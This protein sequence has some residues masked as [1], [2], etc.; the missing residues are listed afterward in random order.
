MPY[1]VNGKVVEKK[2]FNLVELFVT[3]YRLIILFFQSIFSSRTVDNH[4]DSYNSR[5]A[6]YSGRSTGSNIH[7]M[8]KPSTMGGCSGGG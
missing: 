6:G 3:L 2:P 8:A 5:R 1:I 7:R 4:M